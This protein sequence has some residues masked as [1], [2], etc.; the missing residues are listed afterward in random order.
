MIRGYIKFVHA[1]LYLLPVVKAS[2]GVNLTNFFVVSSLSIIMLPVDILSI[3]ILTRSLFYESVGGII[4][5][6]LNQDQQISPQC[7]PKVLRKWGNSF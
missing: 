3:D 2:M 1:L 4:I 7:W 5:E 6:S